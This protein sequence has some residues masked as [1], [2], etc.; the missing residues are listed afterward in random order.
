MKGIQSWCP[1]DYCHVWTTEIIGNHSEFVSKINL[2]PDFDAENSKKHSAVD[3]GIN[4]FIEYL[5]N[6]W[7]ENCGNHLIGHLIINPFGSKV[8]LLSYW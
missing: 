4:E 8:D 3:N 5:Q 1:E 6:I 7:I 2:L